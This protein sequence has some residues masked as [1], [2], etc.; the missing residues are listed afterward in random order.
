MHKF[1]DQGQAAGRVSGVE[2][3]ETFRDKLGRYWV[4][5]QGKKR[6]KVMHNTED[7]LAMGTCGCVT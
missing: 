3:A 7:N 2:A 4:S 5:R 1:V 6:W